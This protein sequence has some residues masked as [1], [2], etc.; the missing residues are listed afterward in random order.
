M[1][2]IEH[3]SRDILQAN[4][5][6]PGRFEELAYASW[7]VAAESKLSMIGDR[8]LEFAPETIVITQLIA[9]YDALHAIALLWRATSGRT[10]PVALSPLL[11]LATFSGSKL[12]WLLR[13]D[14]EA[15][16]ATRFAR[17]TRDT[18]TEAVKAYRALAETVDDDG[19]RATLANREAALRAARKHAGSSYRRVHFPTDADLWVQGVAFALPHRDDIEF[20]AR[21]DWNLLSGDSHAQP[22]TPDLRWRIDATRPT[23]DLERP[24]RV[25]IK[26]S[27]TTNEYAHHVQIAVAVCDAALALALNAGLEQAHRRTEFESKGPA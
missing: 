8:D 5:G 7:N 17:L 23:P 26:T 9:G 24:G 15:P 16:S 3:R 25:R 1:T 10:L 13:T 11:R 22:W 14:L 27:L 21:R 20:Q 2:D 19:L 4:L 6:E 12:I 18:A